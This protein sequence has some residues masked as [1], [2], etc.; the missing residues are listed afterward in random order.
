MTNREEAAARG[1]STEAAAPN[2]YK[3]V[4]LDFD[5][6][7]ADT[8]SLILRVIH[9]TLAE[10]GLPERL[11]EECAATIGLPLKRAFSTLVDMTDET[12]DRCVETYRRLFDEMNLPGVVTIFP[13]VASTMAAMAERGVTLAIASSRGRPTLTAFL[14]DMN[15][16]RHVSM[17]V[18]A[19]DVE[20]AKPE[21]DMVVKILEELDLK[22]E[23]AIVVGDTVFD[24]GMAHAAGVAAVG[25]TYGNGSRAELEAAATEHV[26][27]DFA[28]LLAIV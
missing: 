16:S 19:E 8:C 21:P 24:V 20:R 11:D 1:A 6:T 7:L 26:I 18:G 17:V 13:G 3:C 15:L 25:V 12:C 2:R 23:E 10:L 14:D 5:G 4:I 22:P 27:D 9:R 28:A